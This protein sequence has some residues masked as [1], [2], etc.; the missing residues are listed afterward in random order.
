VDSNSRPP[1][2]LASKE[3]CNAAQTGNVVELQRLLKKNADP[4]LRWECV[5][6]TL[7]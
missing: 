3:L 2:S 1:A 4:S 7:E 6:V 5:S